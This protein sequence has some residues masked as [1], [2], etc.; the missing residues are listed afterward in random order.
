MTIAKEKFLDELLSAKECYC[1]IADITGS[2][3]S[4]VPVHNMTRS[5]YDPD[6]LQT[7]EKEMEQSGAYFCFDTKDIKEVNK[8]ASGY[9]VSF[10]NNNHDLTFRLYL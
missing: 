10:K 7:S 9:D 1:E 8:T 5:E 6:C 4:V 2:V 3:I